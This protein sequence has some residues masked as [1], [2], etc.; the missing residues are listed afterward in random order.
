MQEEIWVP[1]VGYEGCYEVS[2]LGRVR[3]LYNR[4]YGRILSP[5]CSNKGYRYVC[6]YKNKK[7]KN[8][9]VYR[10]VATAF[11]PNPL[12]LPEVDHID[13]SRDN[14]IAINLRWVTHQENINNPIT[15]ERFSK[16][17]MGEKNSFYGRH[18]SVKTR[19]KISD[20]KKKMAYN[21]KENSLK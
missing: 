1:V 2:N 10:L 8:I 3:G 12:N 13:G 21:L 16:A 19:Q 7:S 4:V 15:R 9:K 11:L 18:H 20:T 6:L 14:D 17:Q 5:A